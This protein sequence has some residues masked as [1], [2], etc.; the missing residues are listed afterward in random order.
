MSRTE[1]GGESDA[2]GGGKDGWQSKQGPQP[3]CLSPR[4]LR[5]LET[6]GGGWKGAWAT[7]SRP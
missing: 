1:G 3:E 6:T 4:F 7:H 2:K 5:A